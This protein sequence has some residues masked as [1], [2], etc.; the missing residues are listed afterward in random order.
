MFATKSQAA[1]IS[2]TNDEDLAL[3]ALCNEEPSKPTEGTT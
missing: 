1:R 2:P 3:F